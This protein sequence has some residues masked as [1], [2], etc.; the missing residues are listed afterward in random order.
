MS[1]FLFFIYL[2][3][4]LFVLAQVIRS[5]SS[6]AMPVAASVNFP[7]DKKLFCRARLLR[8]DEDATFLSVLRVALG[9][10]ESWDSTLPIFT[11]ET[12][13]PRIKPAPCFFFHIENDQA[14]LEQKLEE[15]TR[16]RCTSQ[17]SNTRATRTIND[18]L[19]AA[20]SENQAT[21]VTVPCS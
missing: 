17:P 21:R 10:N 14:E 12:G 6:T 1:I 9:D 16:A 4:C 8:L 5:F 19:P 3:I 15:R 20:A 13:W 2:F 7:V 18:V 11:P